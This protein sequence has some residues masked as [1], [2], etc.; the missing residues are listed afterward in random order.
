MTLVIG[1]ILAR[2]S[3]TASLKG[4]AGER[5]GVVFVGD[6]VLEGEA[7]WSSEGLVLGDNSDM[8]AMTKIK[9]E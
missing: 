9:E 5:G 4:M 3:T 2:D 1:S 8:R 7:V 6:D